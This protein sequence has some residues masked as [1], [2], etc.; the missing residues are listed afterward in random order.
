[1]CSTPQFVVRLLLS[2]GLL[3]TGLLVSAPLSAQSVIGPA[4]SPPPATPKPRDDEPTLRAVRSDL[5]RPIRF[6]VSPNS[7]KQ[8]LRLYQERGVNPVLGPGGN[9][10][11][12]EMLPLCSPP[13]EISL[14][15]RSYVFGVSAGERAAVKVQPVL[16]VRDGDQVV[17]HYNS[18]LPLR[19]VGWILLLAGST[20]GGLLLATGLP[21]EDDA[22]PALVASGAALLAVSIGFGL[23]FVNVPDSAHGWVTR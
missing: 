2:L 9:A 16:R 12:S 19:V 11:S 13:C 3:L 5:H 22:K 4:M 6:S 17:V 7:E 20:A 10:D 21:A 1:V 8:T 23:W 15:S 18:R 14:R